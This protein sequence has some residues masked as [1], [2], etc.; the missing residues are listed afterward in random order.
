MFKLPKI[1]NFH[2]LFNS[3]GKLQGC[4]QK[5]IKSFLKLSE[6]ESDLRDTVDWGRKWL[7]DFSAEK[8]QRLV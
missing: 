3:E 7:I 8:T 4:V 2:Y 6:L 5:S 1:T